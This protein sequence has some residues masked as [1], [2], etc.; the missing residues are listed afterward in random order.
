MP[1]PPPQ[2]VGPDDAPDRYRLISRIGKGG[3]GTLWKA[4]VDLAGEAEQVAV[5]ILLPGNAE[6]LTAW[7]RRWQEQA[8]LLTHVRDPSVVGV[9]AAF[10]GAVW[11]REGRSAGCDRTL[12][13]VM[14]WVEGQ[15]LFSW[16]RDHAGPAHNAAR[17]DY[18]RQTASIIDR[19]H[20]GDVISSRRSLLHGDIT[21]GNVMV[22]REGTVVLVDFG[23]IRIARHV[24]RT[25]R[26]TEGYCAPELIDEGQYTVA[27]DRYAF[28]GLTFHLLTGEHPPVGRDRLRARLRRAL[29]TLGVPDAAD[30]LLSCFDPDPA[31]RPECL[32]VANALM[33][34]PTTSAPS[35]PGFAPEYPGAG[36]SRA[37]SG[38]TSTGAP[39]TGTSRPTP[40]GAARGLRKA[41]FVTGGVMAAAVL[42]AAGAEGMAHYG[43]DEGGKQAT[44]AVTRTVTTTPKAS[45]T[46]TSVKH[47]ASPSTNATPPVKVASSNRVSLL[48]LAPLD[49]G[50]I[51][52]TYDVGAIN[53]NG[54]SY[55]QAL[56]GDTGCG[57]N[58]AEW[59]ID[60]KYHWF[61]AEVGVGDTSDTGST[62][63]FD[64]AGEDGR[65]LREFTRKFGE[66]PVQVKVD[67]SHVLR[68]SLGIE[69]GDGSCGTIATTTAVWISPELS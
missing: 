14:D 53:V 35:A 22:N 48:N 25:V 43:H 67:V 13:L 17:L 29:D 2:F 58:G 60:H 34:Q 26:V 32:R 16:A 65:P 5:K 11:H 31:R 37:R 20:N 44:P 15:D 38:A 39:A 27:T 9:H 66:G 41:A 8:E 23:L 54:K 10:E 69:G 49:N 28:G 3:E 52:P 47:T 51:E 55:P 64:V 40:A 57:P 50:E 56:S 63:T 59:E 1:T 62:I 46:S 21:P 33:R 4:E 7:R 24:T 18:L 68:L 61:T 6:D 19:L 36:A 42:F 30:V 45:A 12:Y